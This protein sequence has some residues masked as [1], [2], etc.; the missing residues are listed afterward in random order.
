MKTKKCMA[1]ENPKGGWAGLSQW[2]NESCTRTGAV[3]AMKKGKKMR[4]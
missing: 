4:F 2:H 3:G 1:C